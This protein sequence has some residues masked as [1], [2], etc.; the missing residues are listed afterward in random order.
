MSSST[1]PQLYSF[2]LG[3]PP[4]PRT[5]VFWL[6]QQPCHSVCAEVRGQLEGGSSLLLPGGFQELNPDRQ[7]MSR[8]ADTCVK[9]KRQPQMSFLMFQLECCPPLCRL[10]K[11]AGSRLP[12]QCCSPFSAS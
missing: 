9:V 8:L 12:E 7:A 2:G 3:S 1:S 10:D 5:G 11:L 6:G 4:E